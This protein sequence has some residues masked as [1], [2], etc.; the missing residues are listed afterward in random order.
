MLIDSEVALDRG[1]KALLAQ[2]KRLRELLAHAGRPPLRKRSPGFA[3]LVA[4]IVS[5]QVST[6]SAAAIWKRVTA[7]YPRLSAKQITEASDDTLKSLGLSGPKIR[8]L[9]A[10]AEA[11]SRRTLSLTRLQT[12]SAEDAIAA[13]TSVKG[14]GPWTAEIYLLFCLGHPDA[15]PAGDLALQEAARMGFDLPARPSPDELIAL[16]ERWRPWRGVAAK[17]LW[18]YYGAMKSGREAIPAGIKD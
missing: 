11:I 7:H 17:L 8:T 1:L 10:V 18:A 12:Y 13:L 15:F 14:I 16:A 6:A 9:R 2:D 3:G 5:Q 4:I